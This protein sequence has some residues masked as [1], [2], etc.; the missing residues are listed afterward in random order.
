MEEPDSPTSP[1]L[2]LMDLIEHLV[3]EGRP[4]ALPEV[5]AGTGWP[6]PTVHRMLQQLEAGGWLQ[7]EPDGRRYA[8][9]PRLLRL[10][11]DA[12]GA[13]T[14]H[15]V[16]HAVL[17]QLVAELGESCNLTA[18]SGAEVVYLD[19]VESAFPLRLELRP[20]TRVPLHCSASGK[21]FLAHLDP[22]R[23]R[24]LLDGLSL[25]HHTATTLVRREALEAELATIRR[26]GHAFDAEEF[27]DGLVCI[28]VPVR[29]PGE[30]GLRCALALQA[31]SARVP[32]ARLPA[33]LPRLAQAAQ[34]LA[35]T[36]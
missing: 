21:L 24:A 5:V 28:A 1:G 33:F 7:R 29:A 15:G 8:L 32:L 18:L 22:S 2:R 20:G 3:R 13:S 10:G 35:R 36:L 31:P 6:K 30:R 4:L 19:R 9:A 26:Q 27:V 12:L 34:A 14:Q 16:R 17:R 11:E 23:R 25:T